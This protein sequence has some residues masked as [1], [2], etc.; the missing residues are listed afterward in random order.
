M[1]KEILSH[2]KAVKMP[3]ILERTER[4]LLI[5][6]AFALVLLGLGEYSVWI[7][8]FAVVLSVITVIQRIFYAL[9]N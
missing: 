9:K 8:A 5:M 3:G 6:L 7:I 1:I 2:E 4:V